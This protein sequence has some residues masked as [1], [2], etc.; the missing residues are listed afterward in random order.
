MQKASQ[1]HIEISGLSPKEFSAFEKANDV[2]CFTPSAQGAMLQTKQA[3]SPGLSL[4]KTA[5]GWQLVY[6]SLPEF[7]RALALVKCHWQAQPGFRLS[8]TPNYTSLGL[9]VDCS[10][11][12]APT[13][14][15]LQ[16]MLVYLALLGYTSV[17]LY[18]E[19][20][21]ELKDYSYFG[22]LRGRYTREEL[23]ELDLFASALGLELIPCIQT[24]GHLR[25]VLRWA[26]FEPVRDTDDVLLVGEEET[27]RLID[28]MFAQMSQTFQ[29]RRINIGMDEAEQL[30]LGRYLAL[31][32]YKNRQEIMLEHLNRVFEIARKYGYQPMMWS[33]TFFR[34]ANGGEYYASHAPLAPEVQGLIPPDATLIY[35]DYY[36]EDPAVYSAMMQ[37]HREL[38]C[39]L[40][41]AG[42]AWKWNGFAPAN[43]K[44]MALA[45]LALAAC[46]AHGIQDLLVTAWADN[47]GEA[48]LFSVLPTLAYWAEKSWKSDT[49]VDF[50]AFFMAATGES[51]P[52]MLLLDSPNLAPG[53][54]A[55]GILG[56]SLAKNYFYQDLLL[57]VLDGE[58]PPS[59]LGDHFAQCAALLEAATRRSKAL[60]YLYESLAAM[61]RF[62]EGKAGAGHALRVAYAAQDR[63]CLRKVAEEEL[64]CMLVRLQAFQ[65]SYRRQWLQEN[66]VAG[67]DVFDLRT[68]GLKERIETAR[69][70]L[71]QYLSGEI[72]SLPELE[73]PLLPHRPRTFSGHPLGSLRWE[74][75]ASAST[76]YG[77]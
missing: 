10:R 50:S 19:D 68:G 39:P 26:E 38:D 60:A 54:P 12:A 28:R 16:K 64:P 20:N 8:Q 13:P 75:I 11:N 66:Q 30:G 36:S 56:L 41:F 24:L 72:P 67:L 14:A 52:D 17:Q 70:R 23:R 65:Q 31:H 53:N 18:T 71:C 22:Y 47:G 62:L 45:A 69:Q 55:P 44:S 58:A 73:T 77:L 33:D 35:W 48:S 32:G 9:M 15:A 29:S 21:Y 76:L 1:M 49:S 6:H 46:Q 63:P 37:R 27:Y 40:V 59:G 42:G 2:L 5:G 51:L 57:G 7:L 25:T 43:K 3:E 34:I 74:D 4:V 61:C